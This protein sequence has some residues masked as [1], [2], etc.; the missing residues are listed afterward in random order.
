MGVEVGAQTHKLHSS[1]EEDPVLFSY[2]TGPSCQNNEF[3]GE[4]REGA[5]SSSSVISG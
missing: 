4:M 2:L 5:S 3:M 1:P